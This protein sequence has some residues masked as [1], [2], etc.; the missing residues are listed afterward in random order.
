MY[1]ARELTSRRSSP[2]SCGSTPSACSSLLVVAAQEKWEVHHLDVKFAFLNGEL[3]EEA[4]VSRPPGFI[5]DGS[6][7]KGLLLHR[8]LYGLCQAPRAWNAKLDNSLVAPGFTKCPSE[9]A[10]YTRGKDG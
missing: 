5:K 10:V 9:H 4:Y 8:V 6:E 1:N 7:G 2:P 3:K